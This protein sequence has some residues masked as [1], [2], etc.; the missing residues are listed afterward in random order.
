M[1][2]ECRAELDNI[3]QRMRLFYTFV[4]MGRSLEGFRYTPWPT[5]A[6]MMEEVGCDG[7]V[8]RGQ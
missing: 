8:N 4:V 6:D 2:W 7:K 1:K 3:I 5:V